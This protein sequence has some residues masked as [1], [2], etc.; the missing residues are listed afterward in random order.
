V[1]A[2]S[3]PDISDLGLRDHVLWGS[4][5]LVLAFHG[6]GRL[7]LDRVIELTRRRPNIAS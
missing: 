7:S 3:F 5:L 2:V 4:L 1:A 6:T